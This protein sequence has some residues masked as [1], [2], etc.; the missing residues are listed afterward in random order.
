MP[1]P[2]L[3]N[4]RNDRPNGIGIKLDKLSLLSRRYRMERVE[5]QFDDSSQAVLEVDWQE[6]VTVHY[7]LVPIQQEGNVCLLSECP[8]SSAPS[9]ASAGAL[10]VS[11]DY[12]CLEKANAKFQ[13]RTRFLS[14]VFS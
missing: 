14:V 12:L 13:V 1:P 6:R 8:F 3:T 2:K 10:S 5:G 4:H 11:G 7:R 9:S